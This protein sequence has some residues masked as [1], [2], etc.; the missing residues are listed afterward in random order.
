MWSF[1]KCS[2]CVKRLW[3]CCRHRPGRSKREKREK[4]FW[5]YPPG[6]TLGNK[7]LDINTMSHN[8][9]DYQSEFRLFRVS[10]VH[11]VS[12]FRYRSHFSLFLSGRKQHFIF[13]L[14]TGRSQVTSQRESELKYVK[15][16]LRENSWIEVKVKI[17]SNP[18]SIFKILTSDKRY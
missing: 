16:L 17:S 1:T 15:F 7:N 11:R 4:R 10:S 18:N 9:A 3:S 14:V 2:S 6:S 5:L 8:M 13:P 12:S